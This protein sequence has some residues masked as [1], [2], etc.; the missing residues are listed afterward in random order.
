MSHYVPDNFP[1]NYQP[2]YEYAIPQ[3]NYFVLQTQH[4]PPIR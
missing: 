2:T 1:R 3:K 4:N